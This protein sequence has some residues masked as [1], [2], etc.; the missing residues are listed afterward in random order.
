MLHHGT[1]SH[2]AGAW[3]F[4][5]LA[6]ILLAATASADDDDDDAGWFVPKGTAAKNFYGGVGYGIAHNDYP[7]SNQDGSVTDVNKDKS[8]NASHIF[9]GYQI[10]DNVAIQGGHRDLGDS[11]FT[12]NSSGG[13]SWAA[14][15]VKAEYEAD[16]WELGVMGRW[17]VSQRWYALGFFG[18][19]WWETKETYYETG[20]RGTETQ[21][22][23]DVSLAL[24]FE[25][26]AGLKDRIVYRFMGSHHAVG[27]DDYDVNSASA[28][29]VYRFP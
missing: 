14:G 4:I 2:A 12:G 22:G 25:Y 13:P 18:M 5:V 19:F 15:P 8:D 3:P 20:G 28:A 7:G 6:S 21:S 26:D 10:N 1:E 27:D 9:L 24:G 23:N 29:V 16:G 11:K 17:P